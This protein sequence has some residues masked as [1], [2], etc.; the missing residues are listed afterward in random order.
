MAV[1]SFWVSMALNAWR[2]CGCSVIIT[3]SLQVPCS[4]LFFNFYQTH[5]TGKRVPPW[6]P[7][8]RCPA[9][10]TVEA[11][12]VLP[13]FLFAALA[14]LAPMRWMDTQRKV[15]TELEAIGRQV[16]QYG[17]VLD[18]VQEEDRGQL[19][20]KE[21][22]GILRGGDPALRLLIRGRTEAYVD[23]V[24]VRR[25]EVR[26]A[27]EICQIEV[28]WR[29]PIPYFPEMT[30]G[31]EMYAGIQRRNWV[32]WNGK[33]T[34][35]RS[36]VGSSD[37]EEA[38]KMVYI[39]ATMGRYHTQ[40]ECHYISNA[41]QQVSFGELLWR[42]NQEGKRFRACSNCVGAK[43]D[44]ID[45][46]DTVYIT[47]SGRH[48]HRKEDCGSMASYVRMVPLREVVHLGQCSYCARKELASS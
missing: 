35:H 38:M 28:C 30:G 27:D 9:S 19:E 1:L 24:V 42:R 5:L 43:E 11:A 22:E 15:Q 48:Y 29:E 41:Y 45:S 34:E 40:R 47:Q 31:V 37:D 10:M 21:W 16:S 32:G 36:G 20:T 2:K 13:L 12:L 14:L 7:R 44:Q 23:A 6:I 4:P 3:K 18:A 17:Y 26:G 8:R 39:G 46:E 33:L 25:A